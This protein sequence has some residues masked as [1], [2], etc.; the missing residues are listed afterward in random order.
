MHVLGIDIAKDTLACCLLDEVGRSFE[1]PNSLA[2]LRKLKRTLKPG[3]ILCFESTGPYGKLLVANLTGHFDLHQLNENQIKAAGSMSRTKTDQRDARLI[4][5]AGRR[6]AMFDPAALETTRVLW[7][8]DNENLLLMVSEYERLK[9]QVVA[10]QA[11]LEALSVNPAPAARVIS[12]RIRR[13][14]TLLDKAKDQVKADIEAD[15]ADS[16]AAL[17][18]RSIPG[19]G[20]LNAAALAAKIGDIARFESSDKLKGYVGA[21]PRRFQSG[22]HEAPSRMAKHG[23]MLL[24]HLLWNAAKVA[25]RHNPVCKALF[26]RL[27][28]KGKHAAAAYGAVMR[29]L[30]ELVYGV[31]R[32][33][34]P[35]N[36]E[37]AT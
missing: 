22:R 26:E 27:V 35:F 14:I 8:Q 9:D 4:A 20:T 7:R 13:E 28:A 19:L 31:L 5:E 15:I 34:K 11:Q 37:Y 23:S 32:S 12:R 16:P 2:G 3:T 29:K 21:Y 33:G 24:R 18:I 10:R 36:P 30:V 17:L 25:A 1:V 6:L